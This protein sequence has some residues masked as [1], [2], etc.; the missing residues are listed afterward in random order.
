LATPLSRLEDMMKDVVRRRI[1]RDRANKMGEKFG[2]SG[3]V[4]WG[5]ELGF[6]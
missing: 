3:V 4:L 6:K 5:E 1:K 2:G